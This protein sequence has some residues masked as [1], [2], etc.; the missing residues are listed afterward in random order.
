MITRNK[1][2]KEGHLESS[3]SNSDQVV[4]HYPKSGFLSMLPP[5]NSFKCLQCAEMQ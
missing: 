2:E 4:H 5:A 1:N 3:P